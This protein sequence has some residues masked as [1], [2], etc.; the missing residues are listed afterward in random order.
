MAAPITHLVL[1]NKVYDKFF[2][3]KDKAQFLVG[4]SFP[5]I[6][7]LKEIDRDKTHLDVTSI[8]DVKQEGSFKAGMLF[9][10][11]LDHKREEFLLSKNIYSLCPESKWLTQAVKFA[12]DKLLY[13]KITDWKPYADYFNDILEQELTFDV[14]EIHLEHWHRTLKDYFSQDPTPESR[15]AFGHALS[16]P[17]NVVDEIELVFN[18]IVNIA[19]V[20]T[21][22]GNLYNDFENI[23]SARS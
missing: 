14:A 16:F 7:Y 18:M 10:N 20:K 5:D 19:E 13:T 23:I 2:S 22:T 11:L 15:S 17:Q 21:Y 4:T 8:E 9:H 1:T 3:D 12:E 6:R